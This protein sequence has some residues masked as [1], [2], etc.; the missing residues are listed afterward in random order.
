MNLK[1]LYEG[2]IIAYNCWVSAEAGPT[3]IRY[4]QP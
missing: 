2:L 1:S 3:A 4:V